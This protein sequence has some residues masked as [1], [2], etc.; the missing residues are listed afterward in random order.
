[1]D[2]LEIS[3]LSSGVEKLLFVANFA[4]MVDEQECDT[5]VS[6]IQNRLASVL[7][8][9]IHNVILVSA[10]QAIRAVLH[11]DKEALVKSGLPQ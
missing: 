3:V 5:L 10:K 8:Q 4:D 1:M 11:E 7:G 2:F 9:D 6:S